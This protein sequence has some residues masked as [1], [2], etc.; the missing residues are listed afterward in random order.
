MD[1][2]LHTL[3]VVRD[4]GGKANIPHT[5]LS[6]VRQ[7]PSANS[8]KTKNLQWRFLPE[9]AYD[10]RP[11]AGKTNR[12]RGKRIYLEGTCGTTDPLEAAKVAVDASRRK[13][14]NLLSQCQLTV[15]THSAKCGKSLTN[16]PYRFMGSVGMPRRD[17]NLG[18]I[19][20]VGE[21]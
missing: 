2:T 6:V 16:T 13:C 19:A 3:N 20:V 10:P 1:G 11:F 7:K 4:L 14:Q 17:R 8:R 9:K 21:R 18:T 5:S 12:G 15:P